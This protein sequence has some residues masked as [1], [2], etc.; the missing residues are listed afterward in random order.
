MQP[1]LL[2]TV[3]VL[4]LALVGL[5]V[6]LRGAAER[7]ALRDRTA[8]DVIEGRA[9]RAGARLD[10]RLRRTRVG[11]ALRGRIDR[12]GLDWRVVDVAVGLFAIG[13]VSFVAVSPFVAPVAALLAAA[14]AVRLALAYFTRRQRQRTEQFVAQ[15][16]EVARVLSN[17]TSA[18]LALRS[19]IEM[20]AEDV[21]EPSRG[22]LRFL[23]EQLAVGRSIED[24]LVELEERLPTAS[25]RY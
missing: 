16:P 12:A 22:E 21:D 19:A 20:T 13:L 4:A 9:G 7:E 8:L 5:R 11:R 6:Y 3:A 10:V 14:A 18:G 25:C 24:A 15:L 23:G 1:L 17:A 2:L